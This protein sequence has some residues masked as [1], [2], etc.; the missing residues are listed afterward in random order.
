ML[1]LTF[2]VANCSLFAMENYSITFVKRY[3]L[4]KALHCFVSFQKK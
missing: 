4:K 2:K 3:Y 1:K